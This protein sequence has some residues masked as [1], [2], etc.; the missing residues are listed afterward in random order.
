MR[1]VS[2]GANHLHSRIRRATGQT[3]TPRKPNQFSNSE[4]AVSRVLPHQPLAPHSQ[5]FNFRMCGTTSTG[6]TTQCI[7]PSFPLLSCL[8]QFYLRL[9]R[10]KSVLSC[11]LCNVG[12]TTLYGTTII[13]QNVLQ[14]WIIAIFC[15]YSHLKAML[16]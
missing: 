6:E 9:P 7:S 14:M 16:T 13:L 8:H 15:N 2:L 11:I 5:H 3:T 10:M 12:N 1:S 4:L